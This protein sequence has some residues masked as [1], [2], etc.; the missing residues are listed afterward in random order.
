[1]SWQLPSLKLNIASEIDPWK[2]RFLLET[3][4]FRGCVSF[5]ED[6]FFSF[7]IGIKRVD[8]DQRQWGPVDK[9]VGGSPRIWWGGFF[10]TRLPFQKQIPWS[11]LP[12]PILTFISSKVDGY[13]YIYYFCEV[14]GVIF[15]PKI[16]FRSSE[17]RIK[18]QHWTPPLF[19]FGCPEGENTRTPSENWIISTGTCPLLSVLFRFV[20][21]IFF[22]VFPHLSGEGC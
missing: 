13:I 18:Q 17:L 12:D 9:K 22:C 16:Y 14:L 5:R 4:T 6:M 11:N 8:S 2:R 15:R 19:F 10:A 1:M 20:F 21:S 3:T 7:S